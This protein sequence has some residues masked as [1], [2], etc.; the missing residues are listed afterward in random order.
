MEKPIRLAPL[1]RTLR[2]FKPAVIANET[3]LCLQTVYDVMNGR[4]DNPKWSTVEALLHFAQSKEIAIRT[5][6]SVGVE[7]NPA[8]LARGLVDL[9]QTQ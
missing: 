3:G 9:E 6:L 2:D 8:N 7:G 1:I 5:A 4:Q